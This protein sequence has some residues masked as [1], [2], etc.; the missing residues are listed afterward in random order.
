MLNNNLSNKIKKLNYRIN[1]E[2][3]SQE[4]NS[5]NF[6]TFNEIIDKKNKWQFFYEKNF[7][8]IFINNRKY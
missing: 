2:L 4:N 7:Y 1:N 5:K 8:S 6:D 3:E